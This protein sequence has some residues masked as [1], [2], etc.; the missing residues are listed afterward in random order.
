MIDLR[1]LRENP[2]KY[3]DGCLKKGF[4][5][6]VDHILLLDKRRRELQ[7]ERERLRAEQGK[8]EIKRWNPPPPHGFDTSKPFEVQRGFKPRTHLE[9]VRALN[10]VDF[11]RAVKMAG[12]RSYILT[13]DGM[14]LHL[15]VLRYA[16][17]FMTQKQ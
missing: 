4:A 11:E 7:T 16:V 13:G 10:L 8:V 2:A 12:T 9:L 17:D 1:D 5:V 3:R 6:D 14:R 15:A